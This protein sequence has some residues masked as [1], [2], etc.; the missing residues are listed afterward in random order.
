MKR[1]PSLQK[2]SNH[3][4]EINHASFDIVTKEMYTT[5]TD[6]CFYEKDYHY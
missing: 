3:T 5:K 2:D 1:S 4:C 6:I